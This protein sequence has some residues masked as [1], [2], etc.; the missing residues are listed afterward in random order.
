MPYIHDGWKKKDC[1][2]DKLSDYRRR[3]KSLEH[4]MVCRLR[5]AQVC[6]I[7]HP[8]AEESHGRL[9]A[10]Y[11][12]SKQALQG[13]QASRRQSERSW[14]GECLAPRRTGGS[15]AAEHS[16]RLARKEV[17]IDNPVSRYRKEQEW[18]MDWCSKHNFSPNVYAD[19]YSINEDKTVRRTCAEVKEVH[20]WARD[21]CKGFKFCP[22]DKLSDYRRRVKSLE[23]MDGVL[24]HKCRDISAFTGKK[25]RDDRDST[26]TVP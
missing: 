21:D 16:F 12:V 19:F 17:P 7:I 8:G 1:P 4:M 3:V 20:D 18:A 9:K 5:E 2:R 23:H 26:V 14:E 10:L 13:L 24:L 11:V 25:G 22:R 6:R 15:G